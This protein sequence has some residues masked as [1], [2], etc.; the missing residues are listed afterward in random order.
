MKLTKPQDVETTKSKVGEIVEK[1]EN[2][3]K[4]NKKTDEYG[5]VKITIP[6]DYLPKDKQEVKGMY[7]DAGWGIGNV[8]FQKNCPNK[9]EDIATTFTFRKR[10]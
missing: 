10:I 7:E 1:I 3:F 2:G 9:P 5:C 6:G 4:L 8:T